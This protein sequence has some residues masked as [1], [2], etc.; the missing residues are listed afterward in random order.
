MAGFKQYR[1]QLI[2]FPTGAGKTILF[3][4]LARHYL[5]GRTLVLAHREELIDQ[6][7]QK[8]A[9]AVGVFAQKEKAEFS[10]SPQAEVVV[11][12]VQTMIRRLNKW[13]Q[14]HFSL[15]V[16]DEAHHSISQSWKTVL[17]HFDPHALILGVTAT[18]DRG[19]KRN[20]GQ[21]YE[22]IPSEIHLF[23]LIHCGYLSR[24]V[25][26]CVPLKI[27]L[28][29]VAVVNG[30]Y[31]ASSLGSALAP[32]VPQITQELKKLC[33]TRKKMLVFLPL[34][35]TSKMFNDAAR[36]AGIRSAHVD[37]ESEDR[38]EILRDFAAGKY[39]ILFNAM[40][41]TEGYDC[42]DI[43]AIVPLRATKSRA[44]F[45][46]MIGRGTRIADG[47]ENLCVVDFLW[48]HERHKLVRPASLVA[49]SED[50]VEDAVKEIAEK[51]GGQMDLDL[52]GI[53][54]VVRQQREEALRKQ[55]EDQAHKRARSIDP[56]EFALS[57]HSMEVAEWQDTMSWHY[58]PPT[59]NQIDF[60]KRTG[61]DERKVMSKGHA[62]ALIDLIISRRKLELA[63]PK[64]VR[65]LRQFRY[66]NP[67]TAT[68]KQAAAFLDRRL[69]GMRGKRQPQLI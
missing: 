10:A 32:Y 9:D 37:G 12:S 62:S 58:N 59:Q 60:L 5:P 53:C 43:D 18:P 19:D 23:E 16:A 21:Y 48:Q 54:N 65:L 13:P 66:P 49:Q 69:G 1:K 57:L 38:Q 46:Q 3:A 29:N 39:Q 6:A 47:K 41:L 24:I 67:D 31:E 42:P 35:A 64:Q 63:S 33:E 14:E 17:A 25:V 61:F 28:A 26:R 27:E 40:L 11:A 30:D 8:I 56:V 45:S 2:V 50:E 20:L 15:V 68:F 22:N 55:L 44:L 36:A 52:E 7:I 51:S 4:H 34:I